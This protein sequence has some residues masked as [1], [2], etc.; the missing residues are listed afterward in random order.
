MAACSKQR[1]HKTVATITLALRWIPLSAKSTELPAAAAK[2][3]PRW[4]VYFANFAISLDTRSVK[5]FRNYSLKLYKRINTQTRCRAYMHHELF[6]ERQ[7]TVSNAAS[8]SCEHRHGSFQSFGDGFDS[9]RCREDLLKK[10]VQVF[11]FSSKACKLNTSSNNLERKPTEKKR[12]EQ[13]IRNLHVVK[14]RGVLLH[15]TVSIQKAFSTL[16]RKF[17]LESYTLTWHSTNPQ[18]TMANKLFV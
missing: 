11:P 8:S 3:A 4:V 1:K 5:L 13:R 6:A 16:A 7:S 12:T 10:L 15:R 9:R 2:A 17:G 14:L 18:Q